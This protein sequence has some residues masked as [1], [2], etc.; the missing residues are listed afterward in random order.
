MNIQIFSV[1]ARPKMGMFQTYSHRKL[2]KY[3]ID[4]YPAGKKAYSPILI[5]LEYM[6][7]K[8]NSSNLRIQ[9]K[10]Q[11]FTISLSVDS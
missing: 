2:V 4:Q 5:D 11:E 3:P 7:R 6:T 8:L 9:S 10:N 1:P